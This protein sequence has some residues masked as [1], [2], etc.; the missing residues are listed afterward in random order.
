[1]AN[2]MTIRIKKVT[3]RDELLLGYKYKVIVTVKMQRI[4]KSKKFE[5]FIWL[6]E[7]K[8]KALQIVRMLK[9]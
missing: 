3:N 1:M 6:T 5:R 7:T 2:P 8:R 9:K 4:G